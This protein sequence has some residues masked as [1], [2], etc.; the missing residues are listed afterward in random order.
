VHSAIAHDTLSAAAR[1]AGLSS[2]GAEF[3]RDGSNVMYRLRGGVVARIGRDGAAATARKEVAVSRWLTAVGIP[4]VKPLEAVPQPVIVDNRPV[5]WWKL[6]PAH[7]PANPAEL[8]KVLR[9]VH[10]LAIPRDLELPAYDPFEGLDQRIRDARRL[11][12]VDRTWLSEQVESLRARLENQAQGAPRTV[13]HGDAWQGNVAVLESGEPILLDL[14]KVALG[15]PDMDLVNLAV[16]HTDFARLTD[17]DYRSFVDAYG[18]YDVTKTSTYRT[19]AD[20]QELRWV[21]FVLGKSATS[22]E[23]ARETRHRIACLRGDEPRPWRWTA[24]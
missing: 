23:A 10:G 8:G 16:D 17:E 12:R 24:F 4:V 9:T 22:G 5:T 20:I 13:I 11:D 21:S 14:E 19:L 2:A 7:R 6:L 18:G 3:I 15:H 1:I